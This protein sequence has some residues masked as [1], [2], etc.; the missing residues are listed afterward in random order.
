MFSDFYGV[1]DFN[2][3]HSMGKFSIQ[4]ID[5]NILIFPIIHV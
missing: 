3:Y 4:I 2:H 5:N 1:L